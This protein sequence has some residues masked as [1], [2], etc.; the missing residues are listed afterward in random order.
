MPSLVLRVAI[1]SS[2]IS[3]AAPSTGWSA[4]MTRPLTIICARAV[5]AEATAIAIAAAA[6][7][8]MGPT[9]RGLRSDVTWSAESRRKAALWDDT[10]ND[11]MWCRSAGGRVLSQLTG[12]VT[13][14]TGHGVVR[15]E[16]AGV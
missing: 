15:R 10:K 4:D 8:A 1:P 12:G 3:M 5:D 14:P 13:S 16:G 11:Q 7:R 9:L 6:H 2:R